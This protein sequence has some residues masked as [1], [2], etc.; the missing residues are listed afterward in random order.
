MD[1][2]KFIHL[3]EYRAGLTSTGEAER[4]VRATLEVLGE[5]LS[6][7]EAED[8]AVQ[9]PPEI[10]GYLMQP[11][12][13]EVFGLEEFIRRIS[14]REGVS[15]RDAEDH[16]RAVLSVLADAVSADEIEDA[17]RELSPDLQALFKPVLKTS[18]SRGASSF[19]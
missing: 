6:R 5:R 12:N 8:I 17:C 9:L 3:V 2:G 15:A 13:P 7:G 18:S 11:G 1:H 19:E 14:E 4:A 16:I 10:S